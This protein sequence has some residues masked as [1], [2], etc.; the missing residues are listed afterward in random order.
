M[1]L[2]RL[3]GRVAAAGAVGA[4]A[5]G[6][7]AGIAVAPASAA[8]TAVQYTCN[9]LG[10]DIPVLV[11]PTAALPDFKAGKA[12]SAG[13]LNVPVNFILS[14]AVLDGMAAKG[15]NSVGISTTDFALAVGP[16]PLGVTGLTVPK[17][18][19][20]ATGDM[21]LAGPG[22]NAAFVP[23]TPGTY[24]VTLPATF[25][26]TVD[27]NLIPLGA[28][29][30]ITDPTTAK[31]D[32]VDVVAPVG[33]QG[34]AYTC[35][36]NGNAVSVFV[37][38]TTVPNFSPA[39]S[40][41]TI[42]AAA[43]QIGVDYTIPAAT[44]A[45]LAPATKAT[46]GSADF[47]FRIGDA[48]TIPSSDLTSAEGTFA[49]GEDLVLPAE[50]T[51]EEFTL[52]A[53]GTYDVK[54]PS[55]FT[56]SLATDTSPAA[57]GPC[58]IVDDSSSTVGSMTVAAAPKQSS[59]TK[60]TAPKSVVKGASV[61]ISVTVTAGKTATGKV[62]AKEGSKTLGSGTLKAGK[63]TITVKGL[64]PGKHT[65]KVVYAG[66]STTKGSTSKAVTVTVK[67]KK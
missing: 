33:P 50:G 10:N 19:V 59:T 18:P 40:G 43:E 3:T 24:D 2:R 45:T 12:V 15:I 66:N 49:T 37:D 39:V 64:K 14:R 30:A 48:G 55:T 26:A 13:T 67:K 65:I 32:S 53:A 8:A 9:A 38:A 5:A 4:L 41:A 60:A 28:T 34:S 29:C 62:T 21:T 31:I 57:T 52:P 7:L 16:A 44:V 63:S 47:G 56:G 23:P 46:F 17:A 61:K 22:K 27:T 20:P 1:N 35:T 42:P 11:Q 54:L 25:T 36:I 51:N 58:T 6:A